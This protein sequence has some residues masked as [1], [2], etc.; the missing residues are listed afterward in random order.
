MK[1]FTIS[2]AVTVI[3]MGVAGWWGYSRGGLAGM[4]AAL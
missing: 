2:I 3:L 4:A 1:H